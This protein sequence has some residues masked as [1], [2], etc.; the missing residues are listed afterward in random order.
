MRRGASRPG[1]LNR[2][3]VSSSTVPSIPYD[4]AFKLQPCGLCRDFGAAA[5]LRGPCCLMAVFPRTAA[6][7]QTWCPERLSWPMLGDRS[8]PSWRDLAF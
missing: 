6:T 1:A 3:S 8:S 7:G 5:T 4:V 2:R